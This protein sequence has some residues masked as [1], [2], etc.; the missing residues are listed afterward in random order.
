M[1]GMF[2]IEDNLGPKRVIH[3]HEPII[4]LNGSLVVDNVAAGPLIGDLRVAKDV[5]LNECFG[6]VRAIAVAPP[7][8]GFE[9]ASARVAIQGFDIEQTRR[10]NLRSCGVRRRHTTSGDRHDLGEGRRK[11]SVDVARCAG[12]ADHS[13]TGGFGNCGGSRSPGTDTRRW[14]IS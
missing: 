7:L 1:T 6:V 10:W 11:R 4:G 8:A 13:A 9:L 12:A 5:T 2:D 14:S 3:V